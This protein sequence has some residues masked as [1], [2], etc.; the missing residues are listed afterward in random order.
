M[1]QI[2]TVASMA[3]FSCLWI[4]FA[5]FILNASAEVNCR[6]NTTS[7]AAVGYYTCTELA[8]R[9]RITIE[10]FFQ[11]NPLLD[12]ACSSIQAGNTYCAAGMLFQHRLTVL[13]S[14]IRT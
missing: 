13:A 9:Y 14:L 7:P 1:Y 8:E 6:F 3:F 2:T 10:K 12:P 11:L 5:A 4:I